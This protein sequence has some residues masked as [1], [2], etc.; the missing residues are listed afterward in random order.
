MLERI[1]SADVPPVRDALATDLAALQALPAFDPEALHGRLEE[2]GGRAQRL[3]LA[4]LPADGTAR[5]AAES[6]ERGWLDALREAAAEFITVRRMDEPVRPLLS[7]EDGYYL[8]QN[9]SLLLEQASLALLE[10]QPEVY[11]DS[12]RRARAL[13]EEYLGDAGGE[14][15]A[16]LQG[17]DEL[18]DARLTRQLPDVSGTLAAFRQVLSGTEAAAGEP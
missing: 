11:T 9:L 15:Q 14:K 17:M 7:T 3:P 6:G 5:E 1:S 18:L 2:L 12:L 4:R 13:I 16:I 10:R 8:K